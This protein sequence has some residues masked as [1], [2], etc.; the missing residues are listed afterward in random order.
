MKRFIYLFNYL[1][2]FEFFVREWLVR[3]WIMVY[4]CVVY[5]RFLWYIVEYPNLQWNTGGSVSK[6][7]AKPLAYPTAYGEA[8]IKVL[9]KVERAHPNVIF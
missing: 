1:F 4:V 2:C 5:S 3:C 9:I 6:E 7:P 8:S